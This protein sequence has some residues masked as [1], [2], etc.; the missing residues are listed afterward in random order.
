[1]MNEEFSEFVRFMRLAAELSTK[2]LADALGCSKST[3][4]NYESGHK[5]PRDTIEFEFRLRAIVKEEIKRKREEDY[6][7]TC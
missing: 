4:C 2:Q 7:R 1:M 6:E 3:V 5:I